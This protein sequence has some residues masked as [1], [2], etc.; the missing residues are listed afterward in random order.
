MAA[1][2]AYRYQLS[3]SALRAGW[4]RSHAR[5]YSLALSLASDEGDLDLLAELVESARVQGVPAPTRGDESRP[6]VEPMLWMTSTLPE[7]GAALPPL[8]DSHDA[9]TSDDPGLSASR[10][11]IGLTPLQPGS[12]VS[13]K[14]KSRLGSIDVGVRRPLPVPLEDVARQLGGVDAWWWGTWADGDRLWWSLVDPSGEIDASYLDFSESSP[15]KVALRSLRAALVRVERSES[16]LSGGA[17][18]GP[19]TAEARLAW[20]LGRTLIPDRLRRELVSRLARRAPPLSLVVA[21][22]PDLAQVPMCTLA[23]CD[24]FDASEDSG[25][26]FVDPPRVVEAAIIRLA[27]SATFAHELSKRLPA[28]KAALREIAVAIVD[29]TGDLEYSRAVPA[30]SRTVLCSEVALHRYGGDQASVATRE[31]LSRALVALGRNKDAVLYFSGHAQPPP[32]DAPS[33]AALLLAK[34]DRL[35]ARELLGCEPGRHHFPFP[36]RVLLAACSTAGGES[37]T[38]GEWL[39]LGPAA[40]WAGADVVIAT[41]WP[42]IDDPRTTLLDHTVVEALR[43]S[44]D[45]A[46]ALREV[47]LM[48]LR[49]WRHQ[50]EPLGCHSSLGAERKEIDSP[51]PPYLWSHYLVFGR[52]ANVSEG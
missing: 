31:E 3:D 2:D 29:P 43:T 7:G 36:T 49:K 48:A 45:P 12:A 50:S 4:V 47:Q 5:A 42:V 40:L 37:S 21:P 30:G 44:D 32:R 1:I 9:E 46:A 52:A 41:A 18:M 20:D 6:I 17:L 15:A 33:E 27:P 14:G 39:G 25:V 51:I 35:T 38:T 8:L 24:P 23:L 22:S 26:G 13:V 28:R 19:H 10:A 11:S 34:G 16:G